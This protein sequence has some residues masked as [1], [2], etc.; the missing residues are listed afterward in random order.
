MKNECLKDLEIL[1]E[2]SG[3]H[4]SKLQHS[5]ED[6]LNNISKHNIRTNDNTL[7][8]LEPKLKE[9]SNILQND[10]LSQ[11][12]Q[13]NEIENNF[14]GKSIEINENIINKKI[15]K[16]GNELTK[17]NKKLDFHCGNNLNPFLDYD[18][19]FFDEPT[20][21][22]YLKLDN[23]SNIIQSDK[24]ITQFDNFDKKIS[25]NKCFKLEEDI[26]EITKNW[27]IDLTKIDQLCHK[28]T[29]DL[30]NSLTKYETNNNHKDSSKLIESSIWND[31]PFNGNINNSPN[32]I[33]FEMDNLT[34]PENQI[35]ALVSKLNSFKTKQKEEKID[36]NDKLEVFFNG[37]DNVNDSQIL[38]HKTQ[39]SNQKIKEI[40]TEIIE[41]TKEDDIE[42]IDM[43]KIDEN[44]TVIW[45]QDAI[46][47]AIEL[48]T[49]TP[50]DVIKQKIQILLTKHENEKQKCWHEKRNGYIIPLEAFNVYCIIERD[51]CTIRSIR[52]LRRDRGIKRNKT[53]ATLNDINE[54]KKKKRR[55][56][57]NINNNR[58]IIYS[59]LS[60]PIN[61]SNNNTKDSKTEI[62]SIENENEIISED[63]FVNKRLTDSEKLKDLI[64]AGSKNGLKLTNEIKLKKTKIFKKKKEIFIKLSNSQKDI[65]RLIYNLISKFIIIGKKN[66]ILKNN[67]NFY[68]IS[69]KETIDI[70]NIQTNK[71]KE[72][73]MTC[74]FFI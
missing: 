27:D 56:N 17:E 52:I 68:N 31:I 46:I 36:M 60:Q 37:N 70:V 51:Y 13:E 38:Q 73:Y 10:R 50:I 57:T 29:K 5:T 62:N 16:F 15:E 9:M 54:P 6:L 26:F 25:L 30:I 55:L 28:L 24:L 63:I 74:F 59:S 42:T 20:F 40:E 12:S 58:E 7:E 19:L 34:V 49:D 71:A 21:I 23:D 66:N 41:D 32:E 8:K 72:E 11:N 35:P 64:E 18:E 53:E 44:I 3:E 47:D 33:E 1:I 14:I 39:N 22:N 48:F 67:H 4:E 61:S 43:N 2:Q 69:A 65:L 45:K